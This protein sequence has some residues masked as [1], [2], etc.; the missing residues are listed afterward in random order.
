MALSVSQVMHSGSWIV[1]RDSLSE[2]GS[3]CLYRNLHQTW[4]LVVKIDPNVIWTRSILRSIPGNRF[5]F[6]GLALKFDN[7]ASLLEHG[8]RFG[9][10]VDGVEGVI[11]L[12][13]PLYKRVLSLQYLAGKVLKGVEDRLD[14]TYP[15][16]PLHVVQRMRDQS[17]YF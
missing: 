9:F 4:V 3:Y 15:N 2:P 12:R 6:V 13:R 17:P 5:G 10:V 16:V 7:L 8:H 14:L 11:H 1:V